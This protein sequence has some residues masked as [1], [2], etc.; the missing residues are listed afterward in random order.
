MAG[1]KPA[2]TTNLL[3]CFCSRVPLLATYGLTQDGNSYVHVKVYKQ[4]RIYGNVRLSG[5]G[6]IEIQCRECLRWY[7]VT[8][9]ENSASLEELKDISAAG[10]GGPAQLDGGSPDAPTA[11]VPSQD[12]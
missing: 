5:S 9:S 10:D 3:R 8:L 6:T 11:K 2:R 12:D 4:K 7:R 1:I